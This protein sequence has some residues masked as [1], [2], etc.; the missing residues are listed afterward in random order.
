MIKTE[1]FT[2]RGKTTQFTTIDDYQSIVAAI[3]A[4]DAFHDGTIEHISHDSDCTSIA[5]H[6]YEDPEHKIYTLVFEGSVELQM[7]YDAQLRVIYEISLTNGDGVEV[8]F[9]GT[10]IIVKA[11][12]VRLTMK[13][14]INE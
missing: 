12:I 14:L 11:E 5:F 13:E 6:H 3:E 7:N 8:V 4:R 9:D 1:Q 2:V 10:G